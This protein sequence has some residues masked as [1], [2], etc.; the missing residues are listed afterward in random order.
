MVRDRVKRGV[1]GMILSCS[2]RLGKRLRP[3]SSRVDWCGEVDLTPERFKTIGVQDDPVTVSMQMNDDGSL[4]VA[5]S[6]KPGLC[7]IVGPVDLARYVRCNFHVFSIK[8]VSND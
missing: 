4:T 2:L 5:F 7:A 6:D 8:G 1:L 3:Y